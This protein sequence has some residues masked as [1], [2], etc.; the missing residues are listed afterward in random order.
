MSL[1]KLS[2]LVMDRKAWRAAVLGWQRDNWG[3]EVKLYLGQNKS[4]SPGN[5]SKEASQYKRDFGEGT[6][7]IEHVFL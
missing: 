6:H 3:T 2:E 7:A 1:S 5:C 4:C